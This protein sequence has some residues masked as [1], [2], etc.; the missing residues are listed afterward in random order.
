MTTHE[1]VDFSLS[2]QRQVKGMQPL[3]R[4]NKTIELYTR[5]LWEFKQAP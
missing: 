4:M 1:L 3:N 2:I 5:K